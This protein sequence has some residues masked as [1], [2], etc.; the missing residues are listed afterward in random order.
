MT[1]YVYTDQI[2]KAINILLAMDWDT[3]PSLCCSLLK[4]ITNYIFTVP[5]SSPVEKYS[6]IQMALGSFFSPVRP[7]SHSVETEF[8][9]PVRNIF[10]RLFHYLLRY[11]C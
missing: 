1:Q 2:D 11:V 8:Y 3:T 9:K 5:G 7:I 10:R 6:Q 4:R